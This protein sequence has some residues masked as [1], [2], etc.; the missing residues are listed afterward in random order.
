[1]CVKIGELSMG[2]EKKEVVGSN[3]VPEAS[4]LAVASM[5]G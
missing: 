3:E 2:R 1:M 4:R 5:D